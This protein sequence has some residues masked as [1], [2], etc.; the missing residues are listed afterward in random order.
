MRTGLGPDQDVRARPTGR[1]QAAAQ[2][3]R[4]QAEQGRGHRVAQGG[5]G[6]GWGDVG[7]PRLSALWRHSPRGDSETPRSDPEHRALPQ[8]RAKGRGRPRRRTGRERR[9]RWSATRPESPWPPRPCGSPAAHT[10]AG[11]GPGCNPPWGRRPPRQPGACEGRTRPR[12]AIR[13]PAADAEGSPPRAPLPRLNAENPEND[14][15]GPG[16]GTS[17]G[18]TCTNDPSSAK[19]PWIYPSSVP[20]E[21]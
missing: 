7:R 8:G 6:W 10:R 2:P 18:C 13:R 17:S 11:R 12:A 5:T 21:A 9:M 19:F 15:R 1:R 3:P 14:C 20:L 4:R 16:P